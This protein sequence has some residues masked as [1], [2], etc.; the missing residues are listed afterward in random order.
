MPKPG[1]KSTQGAESMNYLRWKHLPCPRMKTRKINLSYRKVKNITFSWPELVDQES[2]SLKTQTFLPRIKC[3]G[4][5]TLSCSDWFTQGKENGKGK[6]FK[7]F[8]FSEFVW[9]KQILFLHNY[10][11]NE[12]GEKVH[13]KSISDHMCCAESLSHVWLFGTSWTV[14]CQV[15]LSMGILQARTVELVAMPCSRGCSRPWDRTQA[16]HVVGRF[17]T[18]WDTIAKSPL[19]P[20]STFSSVL[21]KRHHLVCSIW[22]SLSRAI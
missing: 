22:P 1:F 3:T 15:P 21:C 9:D 19:S 13:Y 10:K 20:C 12:A 14:A 18:V 6:L 4:K 5:N 16:S 2:W 8:S 17:L 11:E 7:T